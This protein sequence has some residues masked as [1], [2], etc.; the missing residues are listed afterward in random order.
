MDDASRPEAQKFPKKPGTRLSSAS[1]K[2]T[3]AVV[4]DEGIGNTRERGFFKFRL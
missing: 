4:G 3:P 2:T 1:F